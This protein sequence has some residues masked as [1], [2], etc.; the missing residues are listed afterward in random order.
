LKDSDLHPS[1][2][3]NEIEKLSTGRKSYRRGGEAEMGCNSRRE[4]SSEKHCGQSCRR[5]SGRK[6]RRQEAPDKSSCAKG[7]GGRGEEA[8]GS[9]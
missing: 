1:L 8:M 7:N 4:S 6:T 9:D 3:P 2:P 5:C